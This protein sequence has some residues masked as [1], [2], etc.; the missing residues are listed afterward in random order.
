MSKWLPTCMHCVPIFLNNAQK[1]EEKS[2]KLENKHRGLLLK[3]HSQAN[4]YIVGSE[5]ERKA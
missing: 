3:A 5:G 2:G 4:I 1:Y